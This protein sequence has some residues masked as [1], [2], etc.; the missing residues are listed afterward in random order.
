MNKQSKGCL[1]TVASDTTIWH[2]PCS[3]LRI[4][5]GFHASHV[6]EG[7][8]LVSTPIL[9]SALYFPTVLSLQRFI[10]KVLFIFN[11]ECMKCILN[12]CGGSISLHCN[13]WHVI[14]DAWTRD[15][16]CVARELDWEQW[17]DVAICI[18]H[19]RI[20]CGFWLRKHLFLACI[21][22]SFTDI[23][24][25][26]GCCF[27]AT[28]DR[29]NFGLG[30]FVC[31]T[32]VTFWLLNLRSIY[33]TEQSSNSWRLELRCLAK[34]LNKK[35]TRNPESQSKFAGEQ[36]LLAQ[37]SKSVNKLVRFRILHPHLTYDALLNS[38][39][40]SL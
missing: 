40:L 14:F 32:F 31:V 23:I 24:H 20:I 4:F 21:W 16:G 34:L 15:I 37:H 28:I 9:S 30:I 33:W 7:Q 25:T 2:W 10:L 11:S 38:P 26:S 18:L 35:Y 1:K 36:Y 17:T 13:F 29:A 39:K 8:W 3:L 27:L 19:W 5:G 22:P 12:Y 6:S